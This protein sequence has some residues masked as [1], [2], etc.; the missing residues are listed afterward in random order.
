MSVPIDASAA[1]RATRPLLAVD[2]P[3]RCLAWRAGSPIEVR[4]FL[5]EVAALAARLPP[6]RFAVNLCEDRYR[7]LVA[8]CA[9]AVAGQT[10]LLPP[11]RAPRR[12]AELMRAYPSSYALAERRFDGAPQDL[13]VLPPETAAD[14][15]TGLLP[16][17]A[18]AQVVAIGFTSGSTG[19]PKAH[20][21]TWGGLCA[22]TALN[23]R[24]LG[25][26][27]RPL[28]LVVTVPP[29]HM[30]GL[31][32][33]I[34]LPLRS[35]AAI[36]ASQPFFPADVADALVALPPPRL[37]VT[38]PIH[39][40]AL[41]RAGVRLPPLA[42]IVSATAPLDAEL[43][44]QAEQCYDTTLTEVFGSTETC[45]IAH[46]R[47]AQETAWRLYPEVRLQPK[48][49]G[50]RVEAPHFTA[51]VELQDLVESTEPGRFLL[52]GRNGDL[53]EIAGKRASLADLNRRLL[54]IRGVEDGVIFPLEPNA[55]GVCR[56]A[57]LVVAPSIGEAEILGELRAA[58]DPVFMPRPLRRVQALPRT[59]TGK[60]PREAL[61][62]TLDSG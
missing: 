52:R 15:S 34:L 2:D 16:E 46:R 5:A 59:A 1:Q 48:S 24:L 55:A 37:L 40:R 8:F 47:T 43:A 39:L 6:A 7:F 12:I 49:D 53:L 3:G 33:S 19:T 18:E 32:L 45:V 54:A 31:E 62:A 17:L 4:T 13:F 50:T 11:A 38:T 22:S 29:G 26:D 20:A 30:Y 9:V 28:Q 14:R 36:D 56:L 27:Q 42:G 23:A 10:N 60:L 35:A 41:L 21:K 51:P 25:A 61:L 57:A 58:I 44:R